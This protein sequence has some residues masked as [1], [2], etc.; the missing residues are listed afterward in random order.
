MTFVKPPGLVPAFSSHSLLSAA[1]SI[2]RGVIICDVRD[3]REERFRP[4]VQWLTAEGQVHP[5]MGQVVVVTVALSH[6]FCRELWAV[7]RMS[8][9]TG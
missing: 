5:L 8:Q 1:V 9:T 7:R 4:A 6:L 2:E 3:S